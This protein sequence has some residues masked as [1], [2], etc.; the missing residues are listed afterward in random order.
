VDDLTEV[1]QNESLVISKYIDN[2]L[3]INGL[4]FDLRLYVLVTNFD[5]L[6]IY[7][8]NEGLV[9]FASEP[10]NIETI[11]S[12]VYAHLTNYSINKKSENFVQNKTLNERDF[13][14]KWSLSAL[15]T[16]LERLGIDMKAVWARIYDAIIKSLISVE[17]HV[18]S[19]LKRVQNASGSSIKS[20]CFD[21]FGFDIILDSDL[22]PWILEVNLSPSLAFDSPLDFHIK[23]NLIIDALNIV[24]IRKFNRKKEALGK[25][26]PS[27]N[28]K[29]I[30]Q[31]V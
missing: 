25:H 7:V 16:H 3:L 30:N 27:G 31:A 9:R 19:A 1:P 8:Y 10:Y 28:K 11:K 6:K 14:N 5:P 15:Q 17:G 13:G 20:N 2:P 12:N 24:G 21:L 26:L 22:K 4:K 23:S 29:I 18:V